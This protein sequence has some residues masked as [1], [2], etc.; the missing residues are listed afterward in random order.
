MKRI[1]FSPSLAADKTCSLL[2]R[3]MSVGDRFMGSLLRAEADQ[4]RSAGTGVARYNT[5]D[6]KEVSYDGVAL[7]ALIAAVMAIKRSSPTL[8]SARTARSYLTI[9]SRETA[10][11][12]R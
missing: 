10:R 8:L 7:S 1:S 5:V 12:L 11:S 6:A 4:A 2:A 3:G 9:L